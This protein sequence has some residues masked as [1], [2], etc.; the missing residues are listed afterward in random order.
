MFDLID[1]A[2]WKRIPEDGVLDIKEYLE[3]Q[4]FK[5]LTQVVEWMENKVSWTLEART[6]RHYLLTEGIQLG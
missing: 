4:R 3:A 5:T 1:V 6:L 2:V